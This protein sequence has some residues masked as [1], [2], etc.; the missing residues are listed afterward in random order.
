MLSNMFFSLYFS[1][2]IIWACGSDVVGTY[3]I[4]FDMGLLP[5]N[6]YEKAVY[7]TLCICTG[8]QIHKMKR[9]MDRVWVR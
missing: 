9:E 2:E 1:G 7:V 4:E 8:A 6:T 3:E 5:T